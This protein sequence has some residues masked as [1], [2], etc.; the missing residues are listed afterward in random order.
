[1]TKQQIEALKKL[2]ALVASPLAVKTTQH[3]WR[4]IETGINTRVLSSLR[5]LGVIACEQICCDGKVTPDIR[6]TNT[7]AQTATVRDSTI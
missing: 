4:H 5:K 3:G 1:M 6:L 2:A 7:A